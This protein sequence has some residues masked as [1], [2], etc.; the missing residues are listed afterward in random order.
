M[1][2]SVVLQVVTVLVVG[3][4]AWRVWQ[5]ECH[6]RAVR[7]G[8]PDPEH[9]RRALLSSVAA[10]LSAVRRQQDAE[11]QA[12]TEAV[13]QR[14]ESLRARVTADRPGRALL[15][16]MLEGKHAGGS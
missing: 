8:L 16:R 14:V 3:L 6:M 13:A 4:L 12:R 1:G 9:L 5:L 7:D 15:R 2:A 10:A 11:H